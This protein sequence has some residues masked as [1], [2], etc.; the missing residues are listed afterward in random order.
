MRGQLR[1]GVRQ[2]VAD[3]G[4]AEVDPPP[5]RQARVRGEDVRPGRRDVLPG[6]ALAGEEE[7]ACVEG[8]RAGVKERLERGEDVR[9]DG[10]LLPRDGGGGRRRAEAGAERA[11]EEEEPEAAVPGEGLWES[12][13]ASGATR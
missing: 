1:D 10:G 8:G 3:G 5:R 6:V 4:S 11:V 2:P 9:G 13:A 7:G 12:E